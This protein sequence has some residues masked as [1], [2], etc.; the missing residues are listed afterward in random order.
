MRS[1]MTTKKYA[2]II[3][4]LYLMIAIIAGF[5]MGFAPSQLIVAD[6]ATATYQSLVTNMTLFRW[7]IAADVA[8]IILE[9]VITVMLYRLF[10]P[11]SSTVSLIATFSRL[12]M[13]I[14]MGLNLI[15]YMIPIVIIHHPDYLGAFSQSELEAIMYLFLKA[16]KY[17]E[18]GW[19]IFFGIHLL[20]LGYM[21]KKSGYAP[22]LMGII[23]MIGGIGYLHESIVN[24][25]LISSPT[26][27]IVNMVLLGFAVVGEFS[28]SILLLVRGV[29]D[30]K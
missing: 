23:M 2:R 28:F 21:A 18:F 9:T 16:H 24:F 11:V 8:V 27:S 1:I 14:I 17:G 4:L 15:N 25:T 22:K 20:A 3:G 13:A 19:Q 7:T 6:D 29:K 12:A 26:I 10:K 30:M 5:S